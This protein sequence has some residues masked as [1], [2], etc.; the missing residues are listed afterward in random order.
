M[1][2]YY[3][4][5]YRFNGKE[6]DAETGN[7]YYGAR[8]YN[9]RLSQWMSVDPL[10]VKF[11]DLTPYNFVENN[12]VML[13]D[14]NG[15]SANP[16]FDKDGIHLGNTREGYVGEVLI[17]TGKEIVDFSN[18]TSTQ[19][20][21]SGNA[22]GL[23]NIDGDMSYDA[24]SNIFTHIGHNFDGTMVLNT[25]FEMDRINSGCI[26][27]SENNNANFDTRIYGPH[28]SEIGNDFD[29]IGH[30]L[31]YEYTVENIRATMI[32]HEYYSHGIRNVGDLTNN[33]WKA[34]HY[35]ALYIE[36][37][38]I[39]VTQCYRGAFSQSLRTYLRN[40]YYGSRPNW[41]SDQ[42]NRNLLNKVAKIMSKI[43]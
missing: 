2:N 4:S 10:T 32:G 31:M 42:L 37:H 11:P 24:I 17:Y 21:N 6:L 34:Y 29:I 23:S 22:T 27:A 5:P 1:T 16:V 9:P 30:K 3:D 38:N 28:H 39:Q 35:A 20:V 7:Y 41:T 18:M 40:E 19:L 13:I 26:Q 25:R 14:P 36:Q 8:Y 33:H 15:L 12:P 43:P